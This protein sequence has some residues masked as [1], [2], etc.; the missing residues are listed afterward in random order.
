MKAQHTEPGSD[1]I[2]ANKFPNILILSFLNLI[3]FKISFVVTCPEIPQFTLIDF[4]L[5]FDYFW[6]SYSRN[7]LSIGDLA[8]DQ[9]VKFGKTKMNINRPKITG[10][11][12]TKIL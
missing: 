3:H 12:Y 7:N 6:R 11:S 1:C 10:K 2:I 4:F 9:Y 8:N 5:F